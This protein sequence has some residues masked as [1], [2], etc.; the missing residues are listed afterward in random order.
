MEKIR[1]ILAVAAVCLMADASIVKAQDCELPVAVVIGEQT[2]ELPEPA[3]SVLGNSLNRLAVSSGMNTALGFTDFVL[4]AKIDV[5][6]KHILAGPPSQ[7]CYNLGVTLYVANAATKTKF[8][9]A[10]IE[11][12]GVGT[13]ETKSM[14]DALRR[15]TVNHAAV[16]RMIMDG[17]KKIV[18]YYDANY[19]TVLKE[20]ERKA[21]MRRYEE[22]IALAMSIP[23]CSKGYES[24]YTLGLDIYGRYCDKLNLALLNRA[25]AIWGAQQNGQAALEAGELLARIDPEAGCYNDAAVLM[26]EIKAQIRSDLNFEMREKYNDQTE[27]ERAR[28]EA[29]RAIGVA[30]GKGQQPVTT[31]LSWLK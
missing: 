15:I 31:N 30:Y 20:A 24:A 5:L 8:S 1:F 27:L 29:L 6:D 10:Y 23:S 3:C 13:N 4:T 25:R 26:G 11:L 14:T 16:K 17:R 22:A 2:T 21:A 19:Q 12:S 28:I 18:N 7:V 9:S